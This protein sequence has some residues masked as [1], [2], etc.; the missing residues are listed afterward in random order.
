MTKHWRWVLLLAVLVA[1]LGLTGCGADPLAGASWPGVTVSG[2]TTYVAFRQVYAIGADGKM[3]WHFP[4]T[5]ESGQVFFAPPAVDDNLI[6]VADYKDTVF[7]IDPNTGDDVGFFKSQNSRFIAGAALSDKAIFIPSVDGTVY[8]LDR[9]SVKDGYKSYEELWRY[10][11]PG[12]VWG[13][14][15]LTD[16]VLYVT[17]L[18]HHLYALDAETGTLD[19]SFPAD[20]EEDL[21][22]GGLVTAPLLR[23]GILYF[24]SLSKHVYALDIETR[25]LKWSY[26]TTNWVWSTPIIDEEEGLVIGS[27]LDGHVFGLDLETGDEVWNYDAGSSV[28]GSPL[29]AKLD[30]GTSVVYFTVAG[31]PNVAPDESA[32]LVALRTSDGVLGRAPELVSYEKDVVFLFIPTGGKQ[33]IPASFH[34]APFMLGEQ[35][36]VASD[37]G[38]ILLFSLKPSD[39]SHNWQFNAAAE[40]KKATDAARAESGQSSSPFGDP[41]FMNT[42]L[43][44][45]AGMMLVMLLTN[46]SQG[47]RSG[48]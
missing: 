48:K 6:V 43:L 25:K 24:G 33:P 1:V 12:E 14:P 18:N 16:G 21:I 32:N 10:K 29:L 46:R 13:T 35:I 31:K 19:W 37:Q 2:D 3:L 7:G 22:P 47:S 11:V 28:V 34:T 45:M 39:L 42:I 23:E 9:D 26:K 30:D 41:N 38:D 27:D 15:L 17:S 36:A 44:V 5:P 8:A 40:V 20:G 4:S